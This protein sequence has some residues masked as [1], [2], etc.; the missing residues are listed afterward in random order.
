MMKPLLEIDALR[1]DREGYPGPDTLGCREGLEI[2][3]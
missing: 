1:G 2:I 3:I